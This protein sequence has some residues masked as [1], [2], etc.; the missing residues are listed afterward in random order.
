MV[1]TKSMKK[2]FPRS[3]WV[4]DNLLLAGYLP[5]ST[6][7]EE[8]QEKLS[9][10]LDAG[11]RCVIN[12]MEPDERDYNGNLFTDYI[13]TLNQL[14]EERNCQVQCLRFPIRDLGV[15]TPELLQE[16]L[17]A[18]D[19]AVFDSQTPAYVH[20]WG[21]KG[22]TGTVIACWLIHRGLATSQDALDLLQYLRRNDPQAHQPSPETIEQIEFVWN[23]P[24]SN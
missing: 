19:T 7:P 1:K 20:C 17:A 15:P 8:A 2:P 13:P 4:Y 12:L 23:Y 21:G 16:I 24:G 3:Y 22:R 10:L 6:N 11:I 9:A 14:A 18:I 5:G